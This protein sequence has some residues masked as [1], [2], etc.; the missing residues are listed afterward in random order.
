[1]SPG[2]SGQESTLVTASTNSIG[3]IVSARRSSGHRDWK[4][5]FW[6]A[7][8]V[9]LTSTGHIFQSSWDPVPLG[10]RWRRAPLQ[11]QSVSRAPNPAGRGRDVPQG[12][13]PASGWKFWPLGVT[14]TLWKP[15][16]GVPGTTRNRKVQLGSSWRAPAWHPGDPREGGKAGPPLS[17]QR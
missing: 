8:A 13:G 3:K 17:L 6:C 14:D 12:Q 7:D 15:Q 16:A 11:G 4:V 10:R 5:A 1:M 9:K 2:Q